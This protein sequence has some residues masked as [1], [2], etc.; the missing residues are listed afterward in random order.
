M[1]HRGKQEAG[2][3]ERAILGGPSPGVEGEPTSGGGVDELDPARWFIQ[4]R[5]M[6]VA[7]AFILANV[8]VH[9]I[10]FLPK[11]AW[12][13]LML[14]VS[15]LAAL[16]I[17]YTILLRR[18]SETGVWT[19]VQAYADLVLLT[20]LI[21]FSGGIENPLVLLMIFHV[22]IAGITLSRRHCFLV[23]AF[24][25][26]LF[27]LLAW[28]EASG[29]V[30]HYTLRLVPHYQNHGETAHA[31]YDGL[32]VISSIGLQGIILILTALFVTNLADRLRQKERLLAVSA[33]RA[34]T[35]RQLL[36][37]ALETT[38][39]GLYVCSREMEPVL[40]NERW[41]LWM[42]Q[43]RKDEAL[44]EA[45]FG[46]DS[47]IRQ[48]LKES[49][50]RVN[51]TS[52]SAEASQ[53]GVPQTFQATTAPLLDK[54]GRVTHVVQLVRDIT[55]QKK[56]E[57]RMIR[58]GQ[59]AAVGELAGQVAHEVNNPIAII[60]AK[61]RILLSDHAASLSPKTEVELGKIVDLADR[62]AK[63]ASGLLSYCRPSGATRRLI[64]LRTPVRR[65]LSMIEQRAESTGIEI[66]DRL[67]EEWPLVLANQEEIE[68]VFLNL[69]LNSID[70]M[71][72][73]GRLTVS[74]APGGDS[75]QVGISV[76]D[77]GEGISEEVVARIFEPFFT[78]KPEGKGTGL[79]L[80]I[81]EG[82]I[83]HNGGTISVSSAIG[84]GTVIS[85]HLPAS[86]GGA[87]LG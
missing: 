22:I 39:T 50:I 71:P 1:P 75:A 49:A 82:L 70:A 62:V 69:F 38:E 15:A 36:E 45:F 72:R 43:I 68:Q 3:A 26:V 18:D 7:A 74:G 31:A 24:G 52:A 55:W 60:S 44:N 85:I 33:D 12:L 61:A 56:A 76:A 27:A 77:T 16:N 66:S 17:V 86:R 40:S 8:A 14:V 64:D 80:S 4:L 73:G 63:I 87:A 25:T 19:A 46:T 13:P 47:P 5:W 21:H 83:K 10:G 79:G 30:E 58:A 59:L 32:F 37:R 34:L 23:A 28:G 42:D 41:N 67:P 54:D 65:A 35:Q 51:E 2:W 84:E 81:C 9:G 29:A 11:E 78:T 20:L 53:D 48:T 6:A 57:R